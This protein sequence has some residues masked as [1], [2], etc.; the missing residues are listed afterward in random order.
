MRSGRGALTRRVGWGLA[1]QALSSLTNFALVAIVAHESSPREFGLFALVF[2]TY[3]IALGCCRAVCSEPLVVRYSDVF[4]HSWESSVALATGAAVAVGSLI[5]AICVSVGVMLGGQAAELFVVLGLMLPGLLL[6]DTWRYS[7]FAA[8]RGS[9]AFVNDATCALVLLPSIAALLATGHVSAVTALALWGGSAMVG[10]LTGMAQTKLLPNPFSV[11][12]WWRHVSDLALR[13]LGEFMAVAGESQIALYGFAVITSLAAVAAI[14]GGLLL[15]SPLNVIVFGATVS[16]IPEAVRLLKSGV[17]RLM[18]ACVMISACLVLLSVLW[19]G[20]LL[21]VPS[22][23]G[24]ST[25]GPVWHTARPLIL[26][27]AIGAAALGVV[28]GAAIGLRALEAP[29]RSLRARL[30]VSPVI[31]GAGLL[32]AA[33]HGA[34]GGAWGLAIGQSFAAIVFWYHFIDAVADR[35]RR[36]SAGARSATGGSRADSLQLAIEHR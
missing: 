17:N 10:A 9:S 19:A 22:S 30:I 12:S 1:D 33:T 34:P 28:I 15:L 14:R 23:L 8:K 7:F 2:A 11:S 36:D 32:G 5:G 21:I 16:G 20:A 4:A 6:Q 26:P 13:Y 35:R 3:S 18:I 31:L 27:L 25:V 29:R 24:A